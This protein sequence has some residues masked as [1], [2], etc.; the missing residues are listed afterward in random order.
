MPYV[1][2]LEK[3]F[4]DTRDRYAAHEAAIPILTEASC[5]PAFLTSILRQQ[6]KRPGG[7]ESTHYP[8]LAIPIAQTRDFELVANCWIPLPDATTSLST[9]S[10]HHHGKMLLTTVTAFGPGYEHWLFERPRPTNP[11][12]PDGSPWSTRLLDRTPH[13]PHVPAFVD[14]FVAHV[15]FYPRSLSITF[16]L[17]SHREPRSWFDALKQYR[18]IMAHKDWLIRVSRA[19]RVTEAL[20]INVVEYFDF[21][22]GPD[23]LQVIKDRVEFARGPNSDYLYSLFHILQATGNDSLTEVVTDERPLVRQL[24]ADLAAGRP[25][26]GRLSPGH[27]DLENANFS[28]QAVETML[29]R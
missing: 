17:W 5:D 14:A 9:K 7:L 10:I 8:V 16:A 12:N 3:L 23:G 29:G 13:V 15:P 27:T 11:E 6:L 2:R 28:V 26:P 20:K 25:V 1:Q 21:Y 4:R 19:F 22:P 18:L 24:V